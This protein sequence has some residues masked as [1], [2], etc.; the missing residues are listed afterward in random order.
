MV[1]VYDWNPTQVEREYFDQLLVF[2]GVD[3]Q[4]EL[5][6]ANAVA[7]LSKS[8]IEKPILRTIW[9]V[10][11]L[12]TGSS[13]LNSHEF[14]LAMRL[15][16]IMQNFNVLPSRESLEQSINAT[17]PNGTL[18]PLPKF[19]DVSVPFPA[20]KPVTSSPPSLM[21]SN[22]VSYAINA[23]DRAK[24]DAIFA[25]QDTNHDGFVESVDAVGLFNKSG[26]DKASLKQ[27]WTLADVD[28]D[29]RLS[30]EEF[31]IAFHLIVCATKRGL[32]VPE[33]LPPELLSVLRMGGD[34][35]HISPA[36]VPAPVIAPPAPAPAPAPA[37]L[38]SISKSFLDFSGA[39][40][41]D[42]AAPSL[43]PAPAVPQRFPSRSASPALPAAGSSMMADPFPTSVPVSA[44]KP[45]SA[46]PPLASTSSM[47][48]AEPSPSTSTSNSTSSSSSSMLKPLSQSAAQGRQ[49]LD[50]RIKV[51]NQ[52][53][54][55]VGSLEAERSAIL[56]QFEHLQTQIAHEDERYKSLVAKLA[57][58]RSDISS[59]VSKT[60]SASTALQTSV[61]KSAEAATSVSALSLLLSQV[62]K[63][64]EAAD[65]EVQ[66]LVASVHGAEMRLGLLEF[67][68]NTLSAVSKNNSVSSHSVSEE[69]AE[70]EALVHRAK[71][72]LEVV[73]N[74]KADLSAKVDALNAK[75]A[76]ATSKYDDAVSTVSKSEVTLASKLSEKKE[77]ASK[78]LVK[79]ES[80][81]SAPHSLTH[82]SSASM[83]FS[84]DLSPSAGAPAPAPV[85]APAPARP[86]A[87]DFGFDTDF[88]MA[89][90]PA[91]SASSTAKPAA[92]AFSDWDL[93]ASDSA[94]PTTTASSSSSATSAAVS[95]EWGF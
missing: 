66:H 78:L 13:S 75:V 7:F 73:N 50:A 1:T 51:N 79:S 76:V 89:P 82:A 4:G 39:G 18:P 40:L 55:E 86:A 31:V 56:A 2:A 42:T 32:P 29:S 74:Q 62:L 71:G 34:A 14:Y 22:S 19:K 21:H 90:A 95:D 77:V 67:A 47:E 48:V 44:P 63:E 11:R 3:P 43:A 37:P 10:S 61:A 15:V 24:Y 38:Q 64:R 33:M 30:L 41:M 49:A 72:G 91:A 83:D 92:D 52:L 28:R 70:L 81:N 23:Q 26:L 69:V 27:V 12:R 45:S 17:F 88:D 6:G 58:L 93:P 59:A 20:P 87:D 46:F 84:F 60:L 68:S 65:A 85:S 16:A 9:E 57:V 8:G 36:S 80:S 53:E 5:S 94:F 35:M 25:Q 54:A